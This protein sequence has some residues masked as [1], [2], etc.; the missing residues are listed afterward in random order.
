MSKEQICRHC[1][2]AHVDPRG[3]V[4]CSICQ[5]LQY[6]KIDIAN[7]MNGKP[8][9]LQLQQQALNPQKLDKSLVPPPSDNMEVQCLGVIN[10][11]DVEAPKAKVPNLTAEQ[12]ATIEKNKL[13]ALAKRE[14]KAE[15][16][17]RAVES[18]STIN[19]TNLGGGV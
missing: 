6:D 19:T 11:K 13:A 5:K 1:T 7:F 9:H 4:R 12:I 14:A 16:Q 15:A 10:K 18:A 2:Y 3:L 8:T 17:R